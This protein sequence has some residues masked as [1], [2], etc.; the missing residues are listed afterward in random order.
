MTVLEFFS[1]IYSDTK[2]Y[3]IFETLLSTLGDPADHIHQYNFVLIFAFASLIYI[4]TVGKK[5]QQ[6]F[7]LI[8][9]KKSTFG[10]TTQIRLKPKVS[11]K[12]K[13]CSLLNKKILV[14][15]NAIGFFLRFSL[16]PTRLV[17]E[18]SHYRKIST[19][20]CF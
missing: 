7:L 8:I 20:K 15:S 14:F 10:E 12:R 19:C 16:K 13:I 6:L 3:E 2:M 17:Y 4:V 5:K 18:T 9:S 1:W 11:K